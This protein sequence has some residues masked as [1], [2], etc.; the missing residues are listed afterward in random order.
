MGKEIRGY[1]VKKLILLIIATALFFPALANASDFY[2]RNNDVLIIKEKRV[3]FDARYF[4]GLDGYYS[5][6]NNLKQE[7]DTSVE[8]ELKATK[9]K[10]ELALELL[11]DCKELPKD[12]VPQDPKP[13]KEEN[14]NGYTELD[15][16]VYTIFRESCVNCHGNTPQNN[17]L[18]LLNSNGLADL[19]LSQKVNIHD[20]TNAVG[21]EERGLDK[22]PKGNKTL[23]NDE[24]EILRLWYLEHAAKE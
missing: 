11:K 19:S 22:M 5:V 10:L 6:G 20:R 17:S 3:Q 15:K 21:L 9:A 4:L 24:V 7:Y 16:K 2:H 14:P 12:D 13:D 18:S 23:S 1:T 8:D